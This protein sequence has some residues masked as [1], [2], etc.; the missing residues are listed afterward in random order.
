MSSAVLA[1][2][3]VDDL[4]RQ[5]TNANR[6]IG[7]LTRRIRELE[8][9]RFG[10]LARSYMDFVN[11]QASV[12][13][14]C[15]GVRLELRPKNYGLIIPAQEIIHAQEPISAV[16]H[17]VEKFVQRVSDDLRGELQQLAWRIASMKGWC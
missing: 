17:N 8:E 9:R 15:D 14:V 3:A 6:Q 13:Y 7:D 10:P 5:L 2:A 12:D 11:P 1:K 16:A 4:D